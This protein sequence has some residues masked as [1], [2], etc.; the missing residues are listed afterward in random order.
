MQ[1]WRVQDGRITRVIS[2]LLPD[3]LARAIAADRKDLLAL[4]VVLRMHLDLL[5]ERLRSSEQRPPVEA[6][7]PLGMALCVAAGNPIILMDPLLATTPGMALDRI[8]ISQSDQLPPPP[9]SSNGPL[10]LNLIRG[11]LL[12]SRVLDFVGRRLSVW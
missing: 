1:G 9:E 3:S 5:I 6:L 4:A 11:S 10:R 12:G 2:S 8:G 7:R